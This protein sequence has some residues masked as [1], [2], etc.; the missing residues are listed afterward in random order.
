M[1]LIPGRLYRLKFYVDFY[2]TEDVNKR[3]FTLFKGDIVMFLEECYYKRPTRTTL[4][5]KFLYK[6]M[7]IFCDD[8]AIQWTDSYFELI[9]NGS[10]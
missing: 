9:E 4:E 2:S 3:L 5:K 10:V 6:D 1:V 8:G 7:A